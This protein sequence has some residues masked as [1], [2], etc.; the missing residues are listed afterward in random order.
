MTSVKTFSFIM[1]LNFLMACGGGSES[2]STGGN[3]NDSGGNNVI[4]LP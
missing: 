4:T 2:L 3:D 1:L